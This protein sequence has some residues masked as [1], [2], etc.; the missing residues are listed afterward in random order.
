MKQYIKMV[1]CLLLVI[2]MNEQKAPA[3]S[4]ASVKPASTII[5]VVA[6]GVT[7]WLVFRA[8]EKTS[9]PEIIAVPDNALEQLS[10]AS[11]EDIKDIDDIIIVNS[12]QLQENAPTHTIRNLIASI[13]LGT[14]A[15]FAVKALSEDLLMAFCDVM[16]HNNGNNTHYGSFNGNNFDDFYEQLFGNRTG[17][18]KK[19]A[20]KTLGFADG[21]NPTDDDIRLRYKKLAMEK[22]PDRGGSKEEFE[23]IHEAYEK[24]KPPPQ[25]PGV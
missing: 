12:D 22:H 9:V 1:A 23:R 24:L 10:P 21:E 7:T 16:W 19:K 14:V 11:L 4:M 15:G 17:M 5:G 18:T 8:L 25:K 20:L 3:Y 6:G 13:L 2:G